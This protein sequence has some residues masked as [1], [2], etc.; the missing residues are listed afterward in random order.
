VAVGV[1]GRPGRQALMAAAVGGQ[2][3][4]PPVLRTANPAAWMWRWRSAPRSTTRS[5]SPRWNWTWKS[6]ASRGL[7]GMLVAA[8]A[9]WRVPGDRLARFGC[10]C[11]M[12]TGRAGAV[13]RCNRALLPTVGWVSVAGCGGG[14]PHRDAPVD[15]EFLGLDL[16]QVA[17]AMLVA[18]SAARSRTPAR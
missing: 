4:W 1:G 17:R 12:T 3:R 14:G 8:R 6:V 11:A 15:L 9:R 10:H 16:V 5:A 18:N 7:P 2:S 13:R